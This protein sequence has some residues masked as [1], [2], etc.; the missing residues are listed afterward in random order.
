MAATG[1]DNRVLVL[2]PEDAH[3]ADHPEPV[4]H[5]DLAATLDA[6]TEPVNRAHYV[7]EAPRGH[8]PFGV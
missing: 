7:D 3:E 4:T 2:E 6:E 8:D 5:A 1:A